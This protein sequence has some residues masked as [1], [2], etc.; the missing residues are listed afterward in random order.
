MPMRDDSIIVLDEPRLQFAGGQTAFDPHDGLGLFGPFSAGAATPVVSPNYVVIGTPE[1][2]TRFRAWSEAMNRPWAIKDANKRRLWPPYPGFDVAFGS[3]WQEKS[4]VAN[5]IDREQLIEASRKRDAH[6]RCFAV[7]G[8]CLDELEN[9]KK[10]CD[11]L[12][13]RI[14]VALCVIP[15]DVWK[16]CRPKSVIAE[17]SDESRGIKEKKSRRRGQLDLFDEFDPEQYHM[18]PDFRRQLKARA[19]R[20]EM[21]LQIVRESTLRLTDANIFGERGLTPISDRMWNLGSA[22]YYKAGGKP[23]KLHSARNGVCYIGI[24]FRLSEEGG[25]SACCAAQMFL[26]SGDGIVFLGEYGPWYSPDAKQC[27]LSKDAAT[28]LLAGILAT[29]NQL[30]GKPLKEIFL[31]C[32]SSI[33]DEE[34]A[35]YQ[36]ACPADCRLTGVRV[37]ID[38]FG[39]RLYR[40]N[41][42]MPVIR[43]TFWKVSSRAGYLYASGFKP[44]LA[45]YDGWETPLPLRIDVQHGDAAIEQ[46][47]TDILG[48][49]KLNY[50]ACRLGEG[51]PVTVGF[52]N[53]VGEILISNPTVTDRRPNFKYYI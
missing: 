44:R 20:R 7:V 34:F 43:G 26:D 11:K 40:T 2:I 6:E 46:V 5:S 48:L 24:A 27:H 19:M 14:A 37:R 47:A 42:S 33:D 39:P 25:N 13:I 15:D 18:A 1:G 3:R 51:Q 10:K 45:T 50:N 21:P 22:L 38:R 53:A 23:W 8:M 35:G 31:H 36:A 16:N 41:G 17:P 32:R 4:V 29:Y 28:Q 30:D 12:D 52:S 49:T 9:A